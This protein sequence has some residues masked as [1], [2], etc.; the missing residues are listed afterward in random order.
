M[1]PFGW[2]PEPNPEANKR[3]ESFVGEPMSS[4][5]QYWKCPECDLVLAT[6]PEVEAHK[7][8]HLDRKFSTKLSWWDKNFL[9]GM[10]IKPWEDE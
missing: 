7:K 10:A 8:I 4:P 2:F 5:P 6:G 9:Q 1:M 3:L